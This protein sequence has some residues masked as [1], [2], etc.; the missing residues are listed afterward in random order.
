[1]SLFVNTGKE[2]NIH[3]VHYANKEEDLYNES[4]SSQLDDKNYESVVVLFF[5][6]GVGGECFLLLRMEKM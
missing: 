4:S 2:R 1:M 3:V 5:V 6:H